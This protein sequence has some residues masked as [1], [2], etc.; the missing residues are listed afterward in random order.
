MNYKTRVTEKKT[1]EI[2][3]LLKSF[4]TSWNSKDLTLFGDLF[5]EDA[6]YTDVTG[7]S[8]FGVSAIIK[9]HEYPF[10][11][12]NKYAVFT[13]DNLSIRDLSDNLSIVSGQWTTTGSQTQNGNPL[14]DRKGIIQF[15][16]ERNNDEW[17]IKLVYNTDT[18]TVFFRKERDLV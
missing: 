9:Q 14:P 11:T 6:E 10:N 8:A 12:V 2:L 4:A 7:Q 5:T 17:L 16:C 15:I 18:E 1:I 13:I 3:S